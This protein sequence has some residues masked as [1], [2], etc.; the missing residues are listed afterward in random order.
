MTS[1]PSELEKM[2]AGQWYSCL[3][4]ELDA[5]RARAHDAVYEHSLVISPRNCG[6]FLHHVPKMPGSKPGFIV[7]MG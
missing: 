6:R 5:M 1:A 7:P 2:T 4:P 3:D